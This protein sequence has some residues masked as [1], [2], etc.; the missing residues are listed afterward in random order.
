MVNEITKIDNLNVRREGPVAERGQD[1]SRIIALSDGVFG[2]ALTLLAT[3]IGMPLLARGTSEAV[4]AQD[5]IVILPQFATYAAMFYFIVIKWMV[6]RRIFAV[7]VAF[8]SA[9]I[10]LNNLYLLMI[11]FMP[12]PSRILVQFPTQFAP[13]IFF[14]AAHAITTLIQEGLWLHITRNPQLIRPDIDPD[15]VRVSHVSNIG[16][17]AVLFVSIGIALFVSPIAAVAVWILV[18]IVSGLARQRHWTKRVGA[19]FVESGGDLNASRQ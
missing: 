19:P 3:G 10:W 2:F 4:L 6:H 13:V 9:L 16:L 1:L 17:I 5:I 14:A 7:V 15:Y 11:A 8:D 12:V 18:S